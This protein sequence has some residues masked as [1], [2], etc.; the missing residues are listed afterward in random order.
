MNQGSTA[1]R[2]AGIEEMVSFFEDRL[3]SPK[4]EAGSWAEL[5]R[6]LSAAP[7]W[8]AELNRRW[9]GREDW[10]AFLAWEKERQAGNA[11]HQAGYNIETRR[12][13]ARKVQVCAIA[14]DGRAYS[15]TLNDS[16][17]D[18]DLRD[19]AEQYAAAPSEAELLAMLQPEERILVEFTPGVRGWFEPVEFLSDE[20][21][22]IE[23]PPSPHLRMAGLE[24]RRLP[25]G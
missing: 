3:T 4:P 7:P 6:M 10:K 25:A 13:S 20:I 5:S 11:R 2:E 23:C 24:A 17:P 19:L 18:E 1:A 12:V 16:A 8:R 21:A 15:D 9:A 14:D 22:I